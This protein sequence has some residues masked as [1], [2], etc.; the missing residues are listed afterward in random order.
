MRKFKEKSLS[1]ILPD[2][3]KNINNY[4]FYC[5]VTTGKVEPGKGT[6]KIAPT[7]FSSFNASEL[8]FRGNDYVIPEKLMFMSN[9]KNVVIG[10]GI[11]AVSAE[12]LESCT[13]L[14][15][16]RFEEG[17]KTIGEKAFC[18]C[19]SIK[20]ISFPDSLK[21]IGKETFPHFYALKK[22]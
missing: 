4:A 15:S 10:Q 6:K 12:A 19:T 20:E 16:L 21:T 9:I 2:S 17:M 3:V 7:A 13:E 1:L 22:V 5:L 8:I 14:K 11:K 18:G